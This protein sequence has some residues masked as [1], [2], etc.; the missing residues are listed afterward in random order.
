[1]SRS[2][3]APKESIL[4]VDD[5]PDT[6]DLIDLT[7]STAGYQVSRALSGVEAIELVSKH[8]FDVLLLDVMMPDLSGFDV[9]QDLRLRGIDVPP[10]IFLTARKRRE[11]HQTG[12]DLGAH[13]YL[14]KPAKRGDLLD[15]VKEA[16]GR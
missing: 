16:L 10:V 5:E 2:S 11:D 6:V 15:A 7:L 3:K 12:E 9:L 8:Q 13:A 1:M 4:V 14:T